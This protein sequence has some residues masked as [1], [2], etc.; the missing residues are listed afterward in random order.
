MST[1]RIA[2][3]SSRSWSGSGSGARPGSQ[4]LA[5]R[6][7]RGRLPAPWPSALGALH[8][9]GCRAHWPSVPRPSNKWREWKLRDSPLPPRRNGGAAAGRSFQALRPASPIHLGFRGVCAESATQAGDRRRGRDRDAGAR[10]ALRRARGAEGRQLRRPPRRAAGGDRPQRRRQDDA[11][12]DPRR[13]Q[14]SRTAARSAGRRARSAGCPQQA[15]LYRRLT[16]EREPA[17]VRPAGER[18]RHRGDGRGDAR[19]ERARR[20]PRRPGR[21]AVGREPAAD[22]HR[23]RP[24]RPA[25]GPAARRAERRARPAPARAAVGVRARSR[26]RRHDGD[27]LHPQHRRG[28]ALRPATARPRRRRGALRRHLAATCTRPCREAGARDFEE[29]FVAFLRDRGH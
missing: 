13:D 5:C 22:Q 10:Q 19:P 9:C 3:D 6:I 2:S 14:A 8:R 1:Q 18:A 7:N 21:D 25:R 4:A 17:P 27:L 24:A 29:A 23:D 15:A 26:R 16:V 28:G 20:S 11:A 12:L